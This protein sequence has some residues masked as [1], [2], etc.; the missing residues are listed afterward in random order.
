MNIISYQS[1]LLRLG[2][3]VITVTITKEQYESIV[4]SCTHEVESYLS[5]MIVDHAKDLEDYMISRGS[6]D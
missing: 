6:N 3:P 4:E 5:D 2:S 1:L